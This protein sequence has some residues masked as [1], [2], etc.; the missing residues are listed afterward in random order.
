MAGRQ[1]QGQ[2]ARRQQ[3]SGPR[4]GLRSGVGHAAPSRSAG[5]AGAGA[6]RAEVTILRWAHGG[7]GVAVPDDGPWAGRVVFVPGA[8]PGDRLEVE[9]VEVKPRWLRTRV[10]RILAPSPERVTPPCPVQAACGGCPWMVGTVTTQATSRG[11]ILRGEIAKRLGLRDADV[12]VRETQAAFGYRQRARFTIRADRAGRPQAGFMGRDSHAFVPVSR[13]AIVRPA[14]ADAF[15]GLL[16]AWPAGLEGRLTVL[17]G[18][19]QDGS[20]GVAAFAEPLGAPAFTFGPPTVRV[21]FGAFS[22]ALG[23]AAFAQAN[24]EVAAQIAADLVAALGPGDGGPRHAVELFAGSGTLTHA[25]WAAGFTVDAYE[26][27]EAARAPFSAAEE[28][29]ATPEAADSRWSACDLLATGMLLPPP[30][31]APEVVLLDPPRTGARALVPWLRHVAAHTLL[32]VAC[33]LAAALRDLS[34]LLAGEPA[35]GLAPWG[36]VQAISYD[37]FVHSGHQEV[38]FVLRR[39]A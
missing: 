15:P 2:G 21:A 37:M 29:F 39:G 8:V 20:E 17:A 25:L 9:A 13:C 32:Y 22:Q 4:A 7:D 3:A 18:V 23:A 34:E 14:I 1:R 38:L 30:R 16:A 19:S 36:L 10:V 26:V 27:A 12:R 24:P 35:A 31:R 6:V 33:D 28:A 11:L 5:V